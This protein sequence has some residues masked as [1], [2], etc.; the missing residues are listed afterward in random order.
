LADRRNLEVECA[1]AGRVG[2]PDQGMSDTVNSVATAPGVSG[3]RLTVG[4]LFTAVYAL[5][6]WTLGA[7]VEEAGAGWWLAALIGGGLALWR[8]FG[9]RPAL[10]LAL[11]LLVAGQTRHP[12][13]GVQAGR[14]DDVVRMIVYAGGA[15]MV[16]A[17]LRIMK[18][19]MGR[20]EERYRALA[21]SASDGILITDMTGAYLWANLRACEIFGYSRL[22]MLDMSLGR[23]LAAEDLRELPVRGRDRSAGSSVLRECRAWK[24]NGEQATLEISCRTLM[25][26]RFMAIM[27]DVTERKRADEELRASLREKEVLLREIHHRVKNNL[28][29]VSSLINMKSRGV[30]DPDA[31]A[32]FTDSL[33]RI[34]SIAMLH[35]K[36]YLS[37]NLDKIDFA[38]Y[39]PNL[40]M[41]LASTYR[42]DPE[43]VRLEVDV[44]DVSLELD[45]AVPCGLILTE[46]VTNA[47]KYAFPAGRRGRI[48]IEIARQPDDTVVV[49]VA[50]TG[51]GMPEQRPAG[52]KDSLGLKL[53][54]TLTKQ[55][56][57]RLEIRHVEGAEF[58]I[59]FPLRGAAEEGNGAGARREECEHVIA[60]TRG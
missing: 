59:T 48:R 7:G 35:E 6:V 31:L 4:L 60:H 34:K 10:A 9:W 30:S 53:V 25:D 50:D 42:V 29:I 37:K 51:A 55:L 56:K 5:S 21:E 47:L 46:L 38:E 52:N 45:A 26:G 3:R 44:K 12:W 2:R 57:G 13:R 20:T 14:P 49:R 54:A 39:A 23:L 1:N 22:E 11:A 28:Q 15:L 32:R 40:V 41:S 27:R 24:K 36:L 18:K 19:A 43:R 16:L 58:T 8:L 17:S 33:E